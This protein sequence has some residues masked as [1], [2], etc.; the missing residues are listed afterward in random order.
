MAAAPGL[1]CGQLGGRRGAGHLD[2]SGPP[3][4]AWPANCGTA[5][6]PAACCKPRCTSLRG[7]LPSRA[8]W[9][10]NCT[11]PQIAHRQPGEHVERVGDPAVGRIL[12]RHQPKIGLLAVHFLEHGGD[13]AHRHQLDALPE[14]VHRRQVAVA[15]ERARERRPAVLFQLPRAA[16]DFAE[17]GPQALGREGALVVATGRDRRLPP[18]VRIVGVLTGPFLEPAGSIGDSL[19]RWFMNSTNCRSIRSILARSPARVGGFDNPL[20]AFSDG[21]ALAIIDRFDS[22]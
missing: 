1:S 18:R 14:A 15:V 9:M 21:F 7:H 20:T 11:S 17:N 2:R 19:A 6:R 10:R 13:G 4:G 16:D 12:D 5:T 3:A 8:W 22:V